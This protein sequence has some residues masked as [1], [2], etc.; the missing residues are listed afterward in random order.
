MRK[1]HAWGDV[2]ASRRER[3]GIAD[4]E[5]KRGRRISLENLRQDLGAYQHN[6]VRKKSSPARMRQRSAFHRDI[7]RIRNS[8]A[9]KNTVGRNKGPS[10]E[11]SI[12]SMTAKYKKLSPET[13]I[14][15]TQVIARM[16]WKHSRHH[17]AAKLHG[18]QTW[19]MF[20]T[21]TTYIKDHGRKN[22]WSHVH[23]KRIRQVEKLREKMLI[24]KEIAASHLIYMKAWYAWK[25]VTENHL[26]TPY[27]A[28]I[29][30]HHR[31]KSRLYTCFSLWRQKHETRKCLS[32]LI[33][34]RK[35][36]KLCK[37]FFAWKTAAH[38]QKRNLLL[39]LYQQ[40]LVRNFLLRMRLRRK[41]QMFRVWKVQFLTTKRIN[42]LQCRRENMLQGLNR[43][44]KWS[45]LQKI[46][47]KWSQHTSEQR[48]L[49]H[50]S[51]HI[52]TKSKKNLVV[53]TYRMWKL[54]VQEKQRLRRV[55]Q[56]VTARWRKLK[57]ALTFAR[58]DDFTQTGKNKRR[59]IA[60]VI[61]ACVHRRSR[62]AFK[63][64]QRSTS[65]ATYERKLAILQK[66][67]S[68]LRDS[69]RLAKARHDR[70][71]IGRVLRRLQNIN[72]SSAWQSWTDHVR[73]QRLLNRVTSR[74][75]FQIKSKCFM[76]WQMHVGEQARL[77]LSAR[78]VVAKLK[79]QTLNKCFSTWMFFAKERRNFKRITRKVL[80]RLQA[81]CVSKCFTAWRASHD[82]RRR[83]RHVAL[84]VI[85][86]MQ[87][88]VLLKCCTMWKVF[89]QEEQRLRRV[90]QKVTARWRKMEMATCYAKWKMYT[91]EEQRLKRL[92][93]C[94]ISRWL[95]QTKSKCFTSWQNHTDEQV[96]R[97]LLLRRMIERIRRMALGHYFYE[98]NKFVSR[99]RKQRSSEQQVYI[100][101][102]RKSLYRAFDRWA[103]IAKTFDRFRHAQMVKISRMRNRKFVKY[104]CF[105]L[106]KRWTDRNVLHDIVSSVRFA[107]ANRQQMQKISAKGNRPFLLGK[108]TS[109]SHS[110]FILREKLQRKPNGWKS[111]NHGRS[112]AARRKSEETLAG[113]VRDLKRAFSLC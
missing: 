68:L 90:V 56:K 112:R 25:R 52:A 34:W 24:S 17:F 67:M 74:W 84:R 110:K 82:E 65:A 80:A 85:A 89:T 29:V 32:F 4:R 70:D 113:L 72:M 21:L 40:Q 13:K 75:L 102:Q 55:V 59:I 57:F 11:K 15:L 45:M 31:R 76:R 61:K 26:C 69:A 35:K 71:I 86:R 92:L 94:V 109:P 22:S 95:L 33:T 12:H 20:A 81:H 28:R 2:P 107:I 93:N 78:R 108:S 14:F 98:W 62:A 105:A 88:R 8:I 104:Q 99:D 46:L 103:G 48:R 100:R 91:Q 60:H 37:T 10:W 27:A 64:W 16:Q 106:W 54:Y 83:L 77:R 38:R 19:R 44:R 9:L 47:H 36:E 30:A 6:F 58:W 18:F 23:S 50:L 87:R 42:F 79:S 5:A 96:L 1:F 66:E 111:K 49:H 97:R 41:K 3:E 51:T 63:R 73:L 39:N 101:F 43:R 53:I 7:A